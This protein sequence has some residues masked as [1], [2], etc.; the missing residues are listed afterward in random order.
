[1]EEI[2]H[3]LEVLALLAGKFNAA[4]LHYGLGGSLLLYFEGKADVF[5][6]ID[7]MVEEEDYPKMKEILSSL[8]AIE[9][10]NPN[11]RDKT[12]HFLEANVDGVEVD[13]MDGFII[14]KEGKELDASFREDQVER[15]VLVGEGAVPLMKVSL[16]KTY[17]EWMGREN[18]AEMA[19]LPSSPRPEFPSLSVE[20]E[21][22]HAILS[23]L[24]ERGIPFELYSHPSHDSMDGYKA[25]EEKHSC[26]VAK[27][28]F[29][30][31]RQQ[32]V[33]YLLMLP[34]EKRFLTKEVSKQLGV[35]RLSFG[36]EDALASLLHAGKEYC[37]PLDLWFDEGNQVQLLL[38]EELLSYPRLG[39]HPCDNSMTVILST[40][41]LV[42]KFLPA[43]HHEGIHLVLKGEENPAAN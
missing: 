9:P 22:T 41:D 21:E 34:G 15:R 35:A 42:E 14:R 32:T 28:L 36:N 40:R 16:W 10:P 20:K 31:N 5:H 8:G 38:D 24:H 1:M 11:A 3:Q 37:S 4:S 7:F 13:V 17:Y 29:L 43:V 19:S 26:K 33:F 18:K 6:D 39:V 2:Q 23:F 12:R 25:I 30:A 27:N